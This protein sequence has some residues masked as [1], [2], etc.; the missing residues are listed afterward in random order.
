MTKKEQ[1]IIATGHQVAKLKKGQT[2]TYL[3]PVAQ[4]RAKIM[5]RYYKYSPIIHD[6]FTLNPNS[7]YEN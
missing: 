3:N 4:E 2:V 7:Y 5:K 6:L 1:Q